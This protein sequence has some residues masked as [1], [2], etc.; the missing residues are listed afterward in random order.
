VYEKVYSWGDLFVI[1]K[2]AVNCSV[3][4][5]DLAGG[6]DRLSDRIS[7]PELVEGVEVIGTYSNYSSAVLDG[8]RCPGREIYS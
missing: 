4:R 6:F 3:P 1:C 8:V 5:F 7:A 2:V